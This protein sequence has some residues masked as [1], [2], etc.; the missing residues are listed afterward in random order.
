VKTSQRIADLKQEVEEIE[1]LQKEIGA[2]D[3]K[4]YNDFK[5]KI[6]KQ[7]IKFFLSGKYDRNNAILEIFF[8]SRRPGFPGLGDNA[9]ANV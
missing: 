5:A 4:N 6:E 7:E 8:R 2:L 3:E 1:S 9:A